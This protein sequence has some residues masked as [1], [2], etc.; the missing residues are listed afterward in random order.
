MPDQRREPA[1]PKTQVTAEAARKMLSRNDSPDI[2]FDVAV[3][4]YRGC[5]HGCVYCYARPTHAYLG[6]SPGWTS[7]PGWWPRPTPSR[8]CARN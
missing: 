6:Y 1:A 3:N 8:P 2:P 5:E 7:K 4:P